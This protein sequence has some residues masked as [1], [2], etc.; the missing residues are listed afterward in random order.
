MTST[1]ETPTLPDSTPTYKI[2]PSIANL[3]ASPSA[4]RTAHPAINRPIAS[5]IIILPSRPSI[6]H[7]PHLKLPTSLTSSES[8]EKTPHVLLL[9]RASTDSFP[10]LW[11]YPGGSIDAGESSIYEAL[12]REVKEETGL[13]VT[14]ITA[15]LGVEEW[16]EGK[17]KRWGKFTYIVEVSEDVE[18]V[19][20]KLQESEHDAF[21]WASEEG[22]RFM[23][24]ES[25]S[26]PRAN[27]D[28]TVGSPRGPWEFVV[29]DV[30]DMV[31]KG[32][33]AWKTLKGSSA[34]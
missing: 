15:F 14:S 29:R 25:G 33:E 19:D 28:W 3:P 12:V 18:H 20:V 23:V 16:D 4:L 10:S 30:G 32:F 17:N 6:L 11:E 13:S 21:I 34:V 24:E 8:E 26:D 31:L 1:S 22:V 9:Q 2:S 5:A 7:S 27:V